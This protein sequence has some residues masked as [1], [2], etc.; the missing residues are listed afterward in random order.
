MLLAIDDDSDEDDQGGDDDDVRI[1]DSRPRGPDIPSRLCLTF[2]F[3][4]VAALAGRG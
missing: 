4:F 3:F 1:S 2:H